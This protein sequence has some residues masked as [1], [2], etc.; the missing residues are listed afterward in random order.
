MTWLRA[1]PFSLFAP[2]A[3]ECTALAVF[4]LTQGRTCE[5]RVASVKAYWH[6]SKN[7][8]E[9]PVFQK[10]SKTVYRLVQVPVSFVEQC[11]KLRGHVILL[12]SKA[13][14]ALYKLSQPALLTWLIPSYVSTHERLALR[15]VSLW[16]H[17]TRSVSVQNVSSQTWDEDAVA[18][19]AKPCTT[20]KQQRNQSHPKPV[21]ALYYHTFQM[22]KNDK[23]LWG[24]T[25]S[26]LSSTKTSWNFQQTRSPPSRISEQL[27]L[28][29]E[30]KSAKEPTDGAVSQAK[31][32]LLRSLLA[33]QAPG[34]DKLLPQFLE[35]K[36]TSFPQLLPHS[37]PLLPL[38]LV[39]SSCF[40]RPTDWRTLKIDALCRSTFK[41][42]WSCLI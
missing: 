15:H 39:W 17:P 33:F 20:P 11:W 14:P 24:A 18:V 19:L 31:Y 26:L 21:T 23:S 2:H 29:L 27:L 28:G 16:T 32:L 30:K 4:L 25:T 34:Q 12:F 22:N 40:V 42:A 7:I 9:S 8:H 6:Q 36:T 37:L 3:W 38:A 13:E 1:V 35:R 5:Q 10:H 41:F